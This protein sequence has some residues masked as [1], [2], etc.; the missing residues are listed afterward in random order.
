ME[1]AGDLTLILWVKSALRQRM[2]RSLAGALAVFLAGLAVLWLTWWAIFG[3]TWFVL[4][5][6]SI[7]STIVSVI[8]WIVFGLLFVAYF[9][10]NWERLERAEFESPS[11]LR[12]ARAA[13]QLADSPFLALAGPKTMGTFVR[14]VSIIALVGPGMVMTSWKLLQ[15]AGAAWRASPERVAEVLRTLATAGARLPLEDLTRLDPSDRMPTTFAAVRLFDGITL[16]SSEPVGL[17]MHDSLRNKIF[18]QIP[19]AQRHLGS[20]KPPP[21]KVSVKG[22]PTPKSVTPLPTPS[23]FSKSAAVSKPA[24]GGP[25]PAA[26][27]KSS[28]APKPAAP[29][30]PAAAAPKSIP[31][32]PKPKAVSP[33]NSIQPKLK[34][35]PKP[36]P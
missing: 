4:L 36:P 9:T 11:R 19:A 14:A 16:R 23:P 33:P 15:Q 10:A 5:S 20:T 26:A 27:P 30:K 13:A 29:P 31:A 1:P 7:S 8:T 25:K 35:R 28:A 22:K 17:V 18:Q 6:F 24:A 32:S 34:P 2:L 12:V 21:V 3:I